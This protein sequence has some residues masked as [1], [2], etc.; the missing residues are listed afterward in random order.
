MPARIRRAALVSRISFFLLLAL[1]LPAAA[2]QKKAL[3]FTDLMQIRQVETPSISAD[4]RWIAFSARPDRGDAE[5]VV[6]S[7]R[8]DTRYSVA[9]GT[10]PVISRDGAWVAFRVEPSLEAAE[11]AKGD[12]APRRG[13]ALLA[14][15]SGDVTHMDD[16]DSF[17]FSSDGAWLAYHRFAARPDSGQKAAPSDGGWEPG[18]TLVLRELATGREVEVPDVRRYA[19]HG[20]AP[21]LAYSV[22]SADHA[23]DGLYVRDLADG[24][25]T[26][27]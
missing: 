15:A 1:A 24:T 20:D 16:V 14:T 5:G 17:S 25:E 27:V 13:V 19:L 21:L 23:R 10:R 6:R 3:T 9:R 26:T 7:T 18:T 12:D 4:G 2:Q 11:T 22:A 8:S